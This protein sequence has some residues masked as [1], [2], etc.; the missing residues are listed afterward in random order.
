MIILTAIECEEVAQ[1]RLATTVNPR[2]EMTM[3][4]L[5]GRR[6]MLSPKMKIEDWHEAGVISGTI[7]DRTTIG[8]AVLEVVDG[9]GAGVG[10]NQAKPRLTRAASQ[11]RAKSAGF[12]GAIG[13]VAVGNG[14][15]GTQ[16]LDQY[17]APSFYLIVTL[18][19]PV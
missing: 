7:G 6:V 13:D 1:R 5:F 9:V 15:D 11:N 19:I 8:V 16:A 12:Q 2:K 17:E 14:N 10:V 3:M 4:F 18:K